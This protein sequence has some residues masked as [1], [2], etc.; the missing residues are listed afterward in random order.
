MVQ[1]K[2]PRV[3]W[4]ELRGGDVTTPREG[5][6]PAYLERPSTSEGDMRRGTYRVSAYPDHFTQA[7]V[8]DDGSPIAEETNNLLRQVLAELKLLNERLAKEG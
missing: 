4:R 8:N 5:P 1:E 3:D 2:A 7:A 6:R